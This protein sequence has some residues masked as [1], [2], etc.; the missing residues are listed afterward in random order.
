MTASGRTDSPGLNRRFWHRPLWIALGLLCLIATSI[1]ALNSVYRFHWRITV[2]R[3]KATGTLQDIK[4]TDLIRMSA[5]GDPFNLAELARNPNPY[6]AIKNPYRSAADISAGRAA[7]QSHCST[8][9]G[10]DGAGGTGGPSLQG[11]VMRRG[12]SDWAIFQTVSDGI[13]GTAMPPSHLPDRERWSL[14]AY[15]SSLVRG[16]ATKGGATELAIAGLQPVPYGELRAKQLPDRWLM[17]S[18][19]Y[20][21]RQFG[22]INQITPANVGR[23]RLL[24]ARQYAPT[25]PLETSPL[26][27]NG[28]MFVTVPP[29]RV[30]AIDTRTGTLAWA[31]DR[32]L[33]DH[34][35]LCCGMVNRG[36]AVLG[37]TL[38]WGTLDAHLVAL[39]AATG[40][41]RWDVQIADYKDGYSITG[42]P[43]ALHNMVVTGVAGGEFGAPGFIDARDAATGREIWR[44]DAIPKPGQPGAN[45]WEGESWKTGGGPTWMTGSFD[46]AMNLLYWPIGNPSPNFNGEGRK[47]DNLYTDSVVALDADHGTLKWYFQFTP[48]DLFDWDATETLIL[49][50]ARVAGAREHLL[51]Q[52]NRNGFYYL[53]NRE[54]GHFV[55]ARPYAKE[56]WATGIDPNGRPIVDARARPSEQG[57]SVFPAVGGG[58][59]W[60]AA[61]YSPVTGFIYVPTRD[62]AGLFYK[63]ESRYRRGELF[64]GGTYQRSTSGFEQGVVL[65]LEATTGAMRWEYRS[66]VRSVGGLLSTAGGLVFGSQDTYFFALDAS[67]GHQLWRINTGGYT[68]AAP[69][70]FLCAGRQVVTIAAGS[71]LLTFGL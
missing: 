70:T 11:R 27:A 17:Y 71:D 20:D 8:C 39:D 40:R 42:A 3:L 10:T 58:A 66:N 21:S 57:T 36:L 15:V 48:H 22:E 16:R 54:T 7:F 63:D 56:T 23:L 31:Y 69:I 5:P 52:A 29:N 61:S 45:T 65:A 43:L 41:L 2:A 25:S 30:E 67:T 64:T 28:Y 6:L 51:A 1:V 38:F 14:V 18:G 32:S 34:L 12:S 47:G 4:W 26:V 9:H 24:W 50:D 60:F 68:V 13:A 19:S 62:Y 59:N 49:F 44:F 55:L 46:P 37:D 33:P 53:L 35:S